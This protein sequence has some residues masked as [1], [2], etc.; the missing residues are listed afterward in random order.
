V[1]PAGLFSLVAEERQGELDISRWVSAIQSDTADAVTAISE[2]SQVIQ[3][4]NQYQATIAGA[5]EEQ[6]AT[7]A[8][9]SRSVA[10]IASG[11]ERMTLNIDSAA[12]LSAATLTSLSTTER[13]VTD[14]ATASRQLDEIVGTFRHSGT[15]GATLT[16]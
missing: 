13:A 7:T 6:T 1:Q 5:V 16:R 8:E 2:I 11:S 10:Q 9:M 4:I 14:L 3:D 15:G 12:H